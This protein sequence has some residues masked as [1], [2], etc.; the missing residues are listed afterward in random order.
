M[1]AA[2][3]LTVVVPRAECVTHSREANAPV[4]TVADTLMKAAMEEVALYMKLV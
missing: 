2:T 4:V 3:L 1:A